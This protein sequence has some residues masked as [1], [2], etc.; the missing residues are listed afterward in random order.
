MSEATCYFQNSNHRRVRRRT[1]AA[2]RFS[3]PVT[4]SSAAVLF[5]FATSS[6]PVCPSSAVQM[7]PAFEPT[8][9]SRTE[10]TSARRLDG[11]KEL[12]ALCGA[13]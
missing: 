3:Q 10:G 11:T 7:S 12:H 13:A 2:S 5:A 8:P 6:R 1:A 9:G 4:I